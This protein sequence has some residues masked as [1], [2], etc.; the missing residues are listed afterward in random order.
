MSK[1]KRII[2]GILAVIML[3][4]LFGCSTMASGLM[5]CVS[6]ANNADTQTTAAPEAT[7]A[8]PEASAAAQATEKPTE[9]PTEE[10]TENPTTKPTEQPVEKTEEQ[11]AAEAAFLALDE[12]LFLDAATSDITALDQWC[13]DPASFGIDE[14]TVPVTLGEFTEEANNEWVDKCYAW[15]EKLNTIDR[16]LLSDQLQFAYDTYCRYFDMEIESKDWFYNY[17]PLD[18]YVGLHMNMPLFFGL[19][20]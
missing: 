7:T 1:T 4:G 13:E 10:P 9:R 6:F 14:S 2:A 11:K 15:R 3:L 18:E 19:Y 5:R 16:A 8:A 12:E 20:S 17:E